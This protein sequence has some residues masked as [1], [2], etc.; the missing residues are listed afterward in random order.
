VED[1]LDTEDAVSGCIVLHNGTVEVGSK[2]WVVWIEFGDKVGP[3]A[4]KGVESLRK[5]E[6]CDVLAHNRT[7]C[8]IIEAALAQHVIQ[9]LLF[10]D[11]LHRVLDHNCQLTL[12]VNPLGTPRDDR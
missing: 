6:V 12:V 9:A 11:I 2:H 3:Q 4:T 1:V 10:R 5:G 7:L 8:D